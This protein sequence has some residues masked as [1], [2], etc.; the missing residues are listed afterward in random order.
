MHP[1]SL[2]QRSEHQ[3]RFRRRAPAQKI[4]PVVLLLATAAL[5]VSRASAVPAPDANSVLILDTTVSGGAASIEAT[6]AAALGFTV[7][8]VSAAT[9]G[10]MTTADFASYRAIVL[11]DPTCAFDSPGPIAAAEA[12]RAVWGPVINGNAILVGTDPVYHAVLGF[13]GAEALIEKGIGFAASEP[14]KTG[15]YICLSCYYHNAPDFTPVPVL[16]PFGPF[17]VRGARSCPQDSH[18]VATHPALS[19]L[20]DADLSNWTCSTHEGFDS[21]GLLG[22]GGFEALVISEDVTSSF[23]AADGTTGAPYIVALGTT[24]ISD[25]RLTPETATNPLGTTHTVTA[26]ATSDDPTPGTPVV[27]TLVTF[28]VVSGP[29]DGAT[30]TALTDG[31]GQATFTYTGSGGAGMDLI[32]ATFVDAAGATQ[33]SNTAEKIWED[34]G[35]PPCPDGTRVDVYAGFTPVGG[36]APYSDFVGSFAATGVSFASST[37]Y[38]WHPF[39]QFE[40]G[41]VITGWLN[42]AFAGLH[43]FAVD[44]DDGALLFIDCGLVVDNGDPHG[45]KIGSGTVLLAAGLHRYRIEFFEC[46]GGPSGVDLRLPSGVSFA[47]ACDLTCPEDIETC[48]DD[49]QC[50]AVVE[51]QAPTLSGDCGEVTVKCWPPS[52]S[53][54]PVGTTEVKCA[55]VD[56][57]GMV[58]SECRFKVIVKDCEAPQA[59]CRPTTN[60]AGKTIPPA[61]DNP[62]S[63]QNP[64]G[65]YQ[66]LGKDNCDESPAIY[67]SDT[68][69]SFV[70]GPF[71]NGDQVKIT[72]APGVTPNQKPMAGVIVAH[73]QLKGDALL[74]AVDSSGN[75]SPAGTCLVPPPPK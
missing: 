19:G 46:C 1:N 48:N 32:I 55:A 18:I 62:K 51:F 22:P 44:S 64:D 40:F 2:S 33:R 61:G 59:A 41:A 28:T 21:L 27:G 53:V 6:K 10:A 66:L 37:G 16:E 20:T 68:G 3:P 73:I 57:A 54:F 71:S 63:G 67:V 12:N 34:T 72:Q 14:A 38:N 15:A 11:G 50:G 56:C 69:S 24:V 39:G 8:V 31:A 47:C 65:F 35:V 26:T 25:I 74:W 17:T 7:E 5:S 58:V 70:A 23:V 60:P 42:V 52:G 45:P 4:L 9:W 43:T 29:N 30:G 49:G 36:G 75:A 13:A